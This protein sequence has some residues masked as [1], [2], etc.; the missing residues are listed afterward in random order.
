MF[1]NGFP[2]ELKTDLYV[3]FQYITEK[4]Y[5][6]IKIKE[7]K[8]NCSYTLLNG[9]AIN[10]PY[11]IYYLDIYE[12]ISE[13]FSFEQKMIYHAIFTRSCNGFI[14]EKHLKAI[15]SVSYPD[16]IIPYIVKLSDEYV[17]EI[18]EDIY[19]KIYKKDIE[20]LKIFCEL[21]LVN[22]LISYDRMISYWNVYYRN[23][24]IFYKDYIGY[25]LF[26]KCFGY[27]KNKFKRRKNE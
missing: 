5:D 7:T 21:N 11:R 13:F 1:E 26:Q 24:Y 10:F 15:L 19:E 9:E 3:V 14:R 23:K 17:I 8:R 22:F 4:T 25:N 2:I 16:W 18:L 20:K 6:D 27:N 12:N